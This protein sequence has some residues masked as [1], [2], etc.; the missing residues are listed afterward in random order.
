V[1]GIDVGPIRPPSEAASLF[2]RVTRNCPWNRC[3]F[4]PVYKGDRFETR[5]LDE[6][7]AEV[8]RLGDAVFALR[9]EC[10]VDGRGCPTV[11]LPTLRRL[12]R[13]GD[14]SEATRHAAVWLARGGA[15]LF[16]QDADALCSR[17]G[18]VEALLAALRRRFPWVERITSYARARTLARLGEERLRGLRA[19]GLS[20]LHVGL[21][22]GDDETLRRMRKGTT[23][24]EAIVA[25]RLARACGFELCFYVM[26]GLGG[27]ERSAEHAAGTARVI[28][29]VARDAAPDSAGG[30]IPPSTTVRLRTLAIAP[31]TPLAEMAREG[32]FRPLAP[33]EVVA[34]IRDLVARL[35]GVPARLESDHDLNLL[36]ELHGDLASE[37]GP[38][39]ALLDRF[40]AWPL[41]RQLLFALGRR[42]RL[43]VCLDDLEEIEE[44]V[45]AAARSLGAT[46]EASLS[47]CLDRL[48]TALL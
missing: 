14:T 9:S 7:L 20:R 43:V 47:G 44:E 42:L 32:R 31:E 34:E 3:A 39:L 36:P 46:D 5:P 35:A 23:S 11:D 41:E 25:G 18:V 13:S 10:G 26:P 16:L 21:E 2:L 37:P 40:L 19:A 45:V 30:G 33:P 15:T 38:L 29:A 22:S 24:A 27:A 28:A 1:E 12:F 6:L 17:A 48:G 4:C 8:E